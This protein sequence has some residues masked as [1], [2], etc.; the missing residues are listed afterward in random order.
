MSA[1]VYR[2]R[3]PSGWYPEDAEAIRR[4]LAPLKPL[5]ENPRGCACIVP[6]AG[7]RFS[8]LMAAEAVASLAPCD[9]IVLIGGHLHKTDDINYL[10][11]E[12]YETPCGTVE[13]DSDLLNTI[14]RL[15]DPARNPESD[16]TTEVQLPLLAELHRGTP[17]CVLR[18]GPS[19]V[20]GLIGP[21]LARYEAETG[22][23]VG[24]VGSTDLTHYGP[25]YG[26]T[27]HGSAAEAID[28]VR[29][30]NDRRFIDAALKL[31]WRGMN[32]LGMEY[33]AACS[34]GAA[35][36]AASFAAARGCREGVLLS[37]ST[38]YDLFPGDS[39]VG[40]ASILYSPP[41]G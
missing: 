31:D 41:E 26:F 24:V 38:S 17:V 5:S 4:F 35:G 40:Y 6:H 32:E 22:R 9:V 30:V 16:N 27:F 36:G 3:L 14:I 18:A 20:V 21:T 1:K 34:P 12:R 7:W 10:P 8:G 33:R 39:I 19:S 25:D 13:T 29:T 11:F 2:R 15:F 28:W 37:Y 23:R